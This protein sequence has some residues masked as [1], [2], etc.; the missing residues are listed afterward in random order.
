MRFTFLFLVLFINGC[1]FNKNFPLDSDYISVAEKN[2]RNYFDS[3][4]E[5]LD[6]IE[7]VWTEFVVGSLYE[8]GKLIQRKQIPKRAKWIVSKKGSYY[9][10]LNQ[11]GE[12]NKFVASFKP[13]NDRNRYIFD[14]LLTQTNDRITAT[15]TLVEGKRIEMAYDA[16]AGVFAKQYGEFMGEALKSDTAKTLQLYWQFNWLKTFPK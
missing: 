14:C 11:Y 12:Q 15:A 16:P 6:G 9:Q 1:Q 7:G 10:I 3:N 5:N 13:T 4:I 8:D 2:Y